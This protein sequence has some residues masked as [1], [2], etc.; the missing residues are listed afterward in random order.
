MLQSPALIMDIP[1]EILSL[2]RS[3]PLKSFFNKICISITS[4][5]NKYLHSAISTLTLTLKIQLLL[6]PMIKISKKNKDYNWLNITREPLNLHLIFTQ[7][8]QTFSYISTAKTFYNL[9]IFIPMLL[10]ILMICEK[11]KNSSIIR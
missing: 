7:A 5:A 4:S 8:D 3:K 2:F 10:F 1:K 6:N 11:L 9:S